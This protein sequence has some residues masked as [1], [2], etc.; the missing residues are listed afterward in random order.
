MK[1]I[2]FSL[3]LAFVCMQLSH[4][5]VSTIREDFNFGATNPVG[6][7]EWWGCTVQAAAKSITFV[8]RYEPVSWTFDTPLSND[9]YLGAVFSFSAPLPASAN[10]FTLGIT[11]DDA[12]TATVEVGTGATTIPISFAK[13]VTKVSVYINNWECTSCDGNTI[14][15]T[16][17]VI[18]FT[19]AYLI[20][21]VGL[22]ALTVTPGTLVPAFNIGVTSYTVNVASDV[23]SISIQA[24]AID[25]DAIVSGAGTKTLAFGSN[26]FDIKVS[27]AGN[28]STYHLT[29]VRDITAQTPVATPATGVIH[30]SFIANWETSAYPTDYLLSV[31]SK[32]GPITTD[33]VSVLKEDF[34]GITTG[35]NTSTSGT[36]TA[37]SGNTN[38]PT[39]TAAWNAG[40]AVRI[41]GAA[42]SS[43]GSAN[44]S[45]TSKALD[46]SSGQVTVNFKVKGWTT[47]EGY[48]TVKIDNGAAT[49][50]NYTA[51]ISGAFEQ[52]SVTF[53][54]ATSA[55]TVTI[56]TT[57]ASGNRRCFLDDIEILVQRTNPPAKVYVLQD[58]STG[59]VTS[60]Q[61][62]GLTPQKTYYYTLKAT[63]PGVSGSLTTGSSNEIEVTTISDAEV[64][65]LIAEMASELA[66]LK[67][68]TAAL[69]ATNRDLQSQ[70]DIANEANNA[71][72][73][74]NTALKSQLAEAN[75]TISDLQSQ[76]TAA[77][78]TISD[79]Q[80]QLTA[81]NTT[82]SN[83][84]LLLAG[85]NTNIGDLQSQL[86]A[87]NT[88]ISNLQS[89]L[90]AANTNISDLQ[91]Q[92]AA[93]NTTISDLESQLAEC[94]EGY[95][96]TPLVNANSL[97][98]YPNPTTNHI[99][100][101]GLN[102]NETISFY[103]IRG[104][105]VFN[106]KATQTTENIALDHLSAGV[107]FVKIGSTVMK[108]IKN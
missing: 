29:V 14:L 99:I 95:T 10:H 81:A 3:L 101:S 62:T 78:T 102:A 28:E 31:Y 34:A 63:L 9:V 36:A 90:A 55:S 106:K 19:E 83:L 26:S 100:I 91:S 66:Q 12:T 35:S 64:A 67:A 96:S 72:Q 43:S 76:L 104:V 61:V 13:P 79:L 1:K 80:S 15:P 54:A 93:A 60:R 25:P 69:G 82:I 51:V 16:G 8:N 68:D 44:G 27:L 4:A 23:E 50:V 74:E 56:A 73:S 85:A 88:N 38:F 17:P 84:Q 105:I 20:K 103:D 46:L 77:N 86:V 98:M 65:D 21:R 108:L 6:V 58:V 37:W 22:S 71:L 94:M 2:L 7:G 24:T 49:T 47:V 41:G 53:P 45:I 40:G 48:V 33:N 39:V 30:S 52:K 97:Q 59:M 57:A 18:Y 92:L 87:A 5:Q 11:Y 89:Q 75:T 70:L 42:N 32:D 107:Y